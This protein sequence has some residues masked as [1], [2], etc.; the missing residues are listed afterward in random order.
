MRRNLSLLV[1]AILANIQTAQAESQWLIYKA[2]KD[3]P[4]C[5]W[6]AKQAPVKG[7]NVAADDVVVPWTIQPG[8]GDAQNYK[9]ENG[10]VVYAP[11]PPPPKNLDLGP[12]MDPEKEIK[13]LKARLDKLEGAR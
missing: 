8:D 3:R 5:I 9:L 1:V 4:C 7:S 2:G 6:T 13:E 12:P 10:N 11:P